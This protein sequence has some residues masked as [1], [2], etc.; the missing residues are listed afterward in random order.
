LYLLDWVLS[1]VYQ[2][3]FLHSRVCLEAGYELSSVNVEVKY[4]VTLV[5]MCLHSTYLINHSDT[6]TVFVTPGTHI[7]PAGYRLAFAWNSSFS[8][9]YEPCNVSTC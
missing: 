6:F 2:G 3:L 1:N 5:P 9:T 4:A 7:V 8:R